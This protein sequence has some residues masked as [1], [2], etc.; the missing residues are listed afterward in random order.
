MGL[1]RVHNWEKV[2]NHCFRPIE[3]DIWVRNLGT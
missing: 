2:E 3:W 1:K